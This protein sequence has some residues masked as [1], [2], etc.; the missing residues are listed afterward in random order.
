M[1]V[2]LLLLL[3]EGVMK[4]S[5]PVLGVEPRK[6]QLD[7]EKTFLDPVTIEVPRLNWHGEKEISSLFY[8][9]KL[10]TSGEGK[11]IVEQSPAAGVKVK[12]G[13]TVRIY[14]SDKE[15]E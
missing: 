13:S 5:L 3:L 15:N 10:N 8:S 9:L 11:Y 6:N 1:V 2:S 12:E 14:L 7:K 4:D